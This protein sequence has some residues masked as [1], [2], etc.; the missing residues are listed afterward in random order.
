ML[1]ISAVNVLRSKLNL[2]NIDSSTLGWVRPDKTINFQTS[3]AASV[4]AK[5]RVLQAL[6]CNTPYERGLII[7]KNRVLGEFNGDKYNINIPDLAIEKTEGKTFVHGHPPVFAFGE[8]PVSL[9]DYLLLLG[10]KFNKMVAYNQK[11]EYSML[12]EYPEGKIEKILP[13]KIKNFLDLIS[14]VGAGSTVF[15]KYGQM[16]SSLFPADLQKPVEQLL[17]AKAENALLA[18]AKLAKAGEKLMFDFDL[19]TNIA[20]IEK[21]LLDEGIGT[22]AID[23]FWQKFAPKCGYNYSTD[24]SHLK[25]S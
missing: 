2:K 15:S 12:E 20:K 18:D 1:K 10:R 9:N 23:E 8:A 21:Q 25:Q 11:G 16:W 7:D 13:K 6:N 22:K 5:N 3:D 19:S 14:R 24:F 17:H 4:Y